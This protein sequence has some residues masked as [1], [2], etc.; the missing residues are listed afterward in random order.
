MTNKTLK[1]LSIIAI[2]YL[3]IPGYM[4][5]QNPEKQ[6]YVLNQLLDSAVTNNFN[7]KSALLSDDISY[8]R[9][10]ALAKNYQPEISAL[11]S[12]SYWDWL[13]P[14]KAHLLGG[15]INTDM[16]VQVTASQLIYDWG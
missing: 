7:L 10:S 1:I 11:S 9:I 6:V 12:F 4:I 2:I 13:M 3:V 14:N 8:A 5:A 15:D 16:Y